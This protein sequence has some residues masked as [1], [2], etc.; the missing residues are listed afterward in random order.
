[1]RAYTDYPL[2]GNP[3][4]H[5]VEVLVL[6]YDRNKYATVRYEGETDSVKCGYLFQNEALT[7]PIPALAWHLLPTEV[8]GPRVTRRQAHGA[9]KAQ[10]RAKETRYVLWVEAERHNYRT[11]REALR[12]FKRVTGDCQLNRNTTRGR[13][14]SFGPVLSREDGQLFISARRGRH[15]IKKRHLR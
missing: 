2:P 15:F 9:L 5:V 12:H 8:D 3:D 7:R 6:A 14:S 10:R 13:C 4:A 11:L 1:M